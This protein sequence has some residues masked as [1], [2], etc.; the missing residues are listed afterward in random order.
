VIASE[1]M[2]STLRFGLVVG[3][4]TF[5]LVWGCTSP[6]PARDDDG[7][8][9]N[10][11]SGAAGGVGGATSGEGGDGASVASSA[12]GMTAG[13]TSS[14]TASSTSTSG[15]GGAPS[16]TDDCIAMYPSGV[17]DLTDLFQCS[18]CENCDTPCGGA[19]ASICAGVMNLGDNMCAANA[20]CDDCLN[21]A[22][23]QTACSAEQNQCFGTNQACADLNDCIEAC[24]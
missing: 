12:G 2:K 3:S 7:I 18:I 20:T 4:T 8:V 1:T 15:T 22:C 6:A 23:T 24:P 10:A 16:C 17:G 21:S 5:A 19:G 14:T 13:T 11:G 9:T